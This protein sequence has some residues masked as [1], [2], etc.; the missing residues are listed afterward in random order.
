MLALKLGL[1]LTSSNNPGG[2]LP[3]DEASLDAWYQNKKGVSVP[4]YLNEKYGQ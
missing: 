1:S 4:E 3:T 2:W